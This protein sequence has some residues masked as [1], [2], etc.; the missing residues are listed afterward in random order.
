[1]VK[2]KVRWLLGLVGIIFILIGLFSVITPLY[3]YVKIVRFSGM[4]LLLTGFAL[5]TAS[6]S[7]DISFIVEKRSMLVESIV[8][9]L[10]GLIL[11]FNPFLSF[12]AFPFIIGIWILL[13]GIIKIAVS[14]LAR[15]KI[16]GWLFILFFGV[17]SCVFAFIIMYAPLQK[18]NEISRILG[19]FFIT[20]G[21]VLLF[22]ST[23]LKKMH[24]AAGL[25]F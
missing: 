22:D 6:T 19:I 3:S 15:N 23:R 21:S 2:F 13:V 25:L 12:I 17:L 16:R 10:F 18:A 1:M 20:M 4:V 7:S 5:Q 24:E 14:I 11:V 9:Y 8:D